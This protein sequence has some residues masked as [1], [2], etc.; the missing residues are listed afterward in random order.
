V[1]VAPALGLPE[2]PPVGVDEREV[3]LPFSAWVRPFSFLGW[4][5]IVVDGFQLAARDESVLLS[6][7]LAWEQAHA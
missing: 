6:A 5:A 4:A 3:R 2:L 7:A 1:I